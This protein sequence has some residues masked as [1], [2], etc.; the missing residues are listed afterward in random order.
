MSWTISN[1]YLTEA[2]MQGNALEV[3]KYFSGK[4]WTLNAIG[5]I[6]GNM[7]KESNINPGLWQSLK[8][9]NYSGGY[10][11]V[12]WTPATQTG[13]TQTSTISR[14]LM[15]SSIGLMHCQHRKVSGFPPVLIE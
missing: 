1:N 14:I 15:V 11:L 5:G 7:E 13:R 12:Q 2:Q 6:L 8:E 10:G 3:W 4:G 9:G